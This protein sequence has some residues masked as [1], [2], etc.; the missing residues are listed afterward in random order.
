MYKMSITKPEIIVSFIELLFEVQEK[1]EPSMRKNTK[2]RKPVKSLIMYWP[3]KS[4]AKGK[5]G[6]NSCRKYMGR[7]VYEMAFRWTTLCKDGKVGFHFTDACH[8]LICL[9]TKLCTTG[10]QGLCCK[11]CENAASLPNTFF[12]ISV[13]I[14][15]VDK[16]D[17]SLAFS[18]RSRNGVARR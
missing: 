4:W 2:R 1:N 17:V 8:I 3:V 6:K 5:S 9:R 12:N 14:D 10:I 16:Q 7:G 13:I 18:P 15:C 11:A